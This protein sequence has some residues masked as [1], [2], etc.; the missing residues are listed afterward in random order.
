VVRY[1]DAQLAEILSPAHFVGVRTT[2]GGPAPSETARALA[3]SRSQLQRDELR[4]AGLREALA[5]A[6][7]RLTARSRA[8]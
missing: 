7:S 2:T 1:S 8:L 5:A 3:A 6:E 4:A